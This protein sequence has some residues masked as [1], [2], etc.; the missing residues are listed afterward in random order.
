MTM[1]LSLDIAYYNLYNFP[2]FL[3]SV[4]NTQYPYMAGGGR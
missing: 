3:F 1:D 2:K 4:Q